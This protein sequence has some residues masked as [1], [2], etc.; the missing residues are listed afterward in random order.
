MAAA[1]PTR[2]IV[3]LRSRTSM[4]LPTT[5]DP[6]I[7]REIAFPSLEA[8]ATSIDRVSAGWKPAAREPQ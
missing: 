1:S 7:R 6:E 5:A 8:T 3:P 4:L 2:P